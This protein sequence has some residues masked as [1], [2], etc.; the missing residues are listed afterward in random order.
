[1]VNMVKSDRFQAFLRH[2]L[3]RRFIS[4][5]LYF[6]AYTSGGLH[7]RYPTCLFVSTNVH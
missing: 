2:D 6:Y 5:F 7:I 1:M 3:L 4:L